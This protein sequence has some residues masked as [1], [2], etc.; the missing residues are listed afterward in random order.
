M[1][2]IGAKLYFPFFDHIMQNSDIFWKPALAVQGDA[3]S[4]M[5]ELQKSLR[6]FKCDADWIKTL[7]AR[8]EEKEIA[9][10]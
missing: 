7:T 2:C 1:K 8:D 6:G 4:F 10:L 9:N 3:A 5:V